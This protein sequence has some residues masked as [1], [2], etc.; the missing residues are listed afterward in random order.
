MC[1]RNQQRLYKSIDV[2]IFKIYIH[3]I[4]QPIYCSF[5]N[6]FALINYQQYDYNIQFNVF[7]L[8]T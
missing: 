2:N 7:I 4:V 6:E 5:A 8:V 1:K 3:L